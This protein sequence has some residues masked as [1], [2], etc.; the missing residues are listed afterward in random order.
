MPT[1]SWCFDRCQSKKSHFT[2]IG[3]R[4][5]S[6]FIFFKFF[7]AFFASFARLLQHIMQNGNQLASKFYVELLTSL[8]EPF[9]LS[10]SKKFFWRLTFLRPY[11]V[12]KM[13]G[14]TRVQWQ[15]RHLNF[16]SKLRCSI[17]HFSFV[18]VLS[19]ARQQTLSGL[20][21]FHNPVIGDRMD[22]MTILYQHLFTV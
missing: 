7:E 16:K 2:Q 19:A 13:N 12:S 21:P 3:R 22:Y 15:M 11:H 18:Q 1:A 17:R 10:S 14:L 6:F 5:S 8:N 9:P 4:K 20:I